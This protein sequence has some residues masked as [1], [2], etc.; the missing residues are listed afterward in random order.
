VDETGFVGLKCHSTLP[1]LLF[2]VRYDLSLDRYYSL[3]F[4]CAYYLGVKVVDESNRSSSPIGLPFDE[5]GI[6]EDV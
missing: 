6:I 2:S 1:R 4:V 5:V 3:T